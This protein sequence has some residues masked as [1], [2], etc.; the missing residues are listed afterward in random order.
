MVSCGVHSGPR[1]L[2]LALRPEAGWLYLHR[3]RVG[4]QAPATKKDRRDAARRSRPDVTSDY[5]CGMREGVRGF[6]GIADLERCSTL[7]RC[8]RSFKNPIT[9]VVA[10]PWAVLGSP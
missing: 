8:A 2:R 5:A 7:F 9:L 10:V 3:R 6:G 4:V 1:S